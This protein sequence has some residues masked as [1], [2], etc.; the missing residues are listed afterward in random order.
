MWA[1]VSS[2][3]ANTQEITGIAA[4]FMLTKTSE[5]VVLP[6]EVELQ[7]F[8]ELLSPEPVV[9]VLHRRLEGVRGPEADVLPQPHDGEE[10]AVV[11][12]GVVG[13]EPLDEP[14]HAHRPRVVP[15]HHG[16]SGVARLVHGGYSLADRALVA[17][18]RV[19]VVHDRGRD[20]DLAR[21]DADDLGEGVDV[22]L[23]APVV[24]TGGV[25]ALAERLPLHH[26]Q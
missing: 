21:G 23:V 3:G 9:G 10:G 25:V 19:D 6:A 22:R 8:A 26:P 18:A 24:A 11:P 17:L 20:E 4:L 12:G 14:A 2:D 5:E 13:R 16:G 15:G 7:R 1:G